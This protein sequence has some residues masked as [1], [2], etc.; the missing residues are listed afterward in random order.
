MTFHNCVGRFARTSSND[1][2]QGSFSNF[3]NCV[4]KAS[5]SEL[6]ELNILFEE[7]IDA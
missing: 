7:F 3:W 5:E 6:Q 2:V 4:N 1:V